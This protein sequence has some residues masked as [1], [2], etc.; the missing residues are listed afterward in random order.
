MSNKIPYLTPI[1]NDLK[2]FDGVNG[3]FAIPNAQFYEDKPTHA[4]KVA[5][6]AA[7]KA[8]ANKQKEGNSQSA[9]ST[10]SNSA[11]P[12]AAAS[13]GVAAANAKNTVAKPVIQYKYKLRDIPRALSKVKGETADKFLSKFFSGELNYS[14]DKQ[15]A[16][17]GINQNGKPYAPEFVESKTVKLDWVLEQSSAGQSDGYGKKQY[18][19]LI[20]QAYLTQVNSKDKDQTLLASA[21]RL[22]TSPSKDY[23]YAE[24]I[25]IF[26]RCGSDYQMLHSYHFQQIEINSALFFWKDLGMTL[27]NFNLY[28]APSKA[29][30]D[31]YREGDITATITEICVYV[32][33]MF[34]FRGEN[35]YLASCN[36]NGVI[37]VDNTAAALLGH[38]NQY[39]KNRKIKL[40]NPKGVG[41]HVAIKEP[42]AEDNIFWNVMKN[43]LVEWQD[44]YQQGGDFIVFSD[45]KKVKLD[46]PI[47]VDVVSVR[48]H[49][50][51]KISDKGIAF[52]GEWESGVMNGN[53]WQGLPVTEGMILKVYDDGYAI[54]TVG[55]GHRVHPG[56]RLVL[57][58]LITLERAREFF[59][60]D[61]AT[62]ENAVNKNINVPLY[63]YEYDALVSIL[64]NTGIQRGSNDSSSKTRIERVADIV[65]A[66]DYSKASDF[67]LDFIAGRV[68]K[69]RV[70]EAS[71]FKTGVYDA[72]H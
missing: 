54:P 41:K 65:N 51:W 9:S 40:A 7:E 70:S 3:C 21:K 2:L 11:A 27:G 32:R 26:E 49:K 15:A 12:A 35:G 60:N 4:E 46:K 25:D 50:P 63:Q 36:K 38:I 72:K 66:G 62:F 29:T 55:F 59:R 31:Y 13:G 67:I 45:F 18:E 53:N 39:K 30:I 48:R 8:A 43:D 1:S 28:V 17:N 20:S 64:F 58:D 42:L 37:F 19:T 52:M 16:K 69:R 5:A 71:L 33:K 34:S 10:A 23:R 57:G 61:V 68:P 14:P 24:R 56:D 47:V 44:T 6:A 22:P